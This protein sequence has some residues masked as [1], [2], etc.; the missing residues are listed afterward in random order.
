MKYF[1]GQMDVFM[2]VWGNFFVNI[3]DK[4]GTR[5]HCSKKGHL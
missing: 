5:L 1:D 4:R 3:G 2:R